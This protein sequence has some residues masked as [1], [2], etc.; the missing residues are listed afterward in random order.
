MENLSQLKEFFKGQVRDSYD[1]YS[2]GVWR[3]EEYMGFTEYYSKR[4]FDAL[5]D[6]AK[7]SEGD[8]ISIISRITGDDKE[9][10]L[11]VLRKI[12]HE[13]LLEYHHIGKKRGK[14]RKKE[15]FYNATQIVMVC[16]EYESAKEKVLNDNIIKEKAKSELQLLEN[17]LKE[18]ANKGKWFARVSRVPNGFVYI[19]YYEMKGKFGWFDSNPKYNLPEYYSGYI[20]ENEHDLND[21]KE[22]KRKIEDLKE[23]IYQ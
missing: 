15:Y 21:Y 5:E 9:L 1:N 7:R 3:P 18:L 8:L 20:F 23:L 2:V 6:P 10:V 12:I 11:K 17:E 4:A 16:E 14:N 22:I 19:V 13:D